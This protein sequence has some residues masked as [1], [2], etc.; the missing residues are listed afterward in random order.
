MKEKRLCFGCL[1]PDHNAKDC[2]HRLSCEN[3]KKGHPTCLHD[4]NFIK[5]NP[6]STSKESSSEETVT[7]LSLSTE[8]EEPSVNTSMIVPVWVSSVSHP[9]R[10][11]LVKA[12]LESQSDSLHRQGNK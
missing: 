12:L 3:C 1:K 9:G 2:R 10:E 7:T 4:D 8:T 5:V 11:K 6:V